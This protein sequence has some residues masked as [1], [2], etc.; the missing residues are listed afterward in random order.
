MPQWTREQLRAIEA[1]GGNVLLSAAAGSGKTTVLVERVLRMIADEGAD[2]DRMLV[3]TF[4]RAAASDMRA[5]LSR[6]LSARAAAGDARCRDQLLLLDRASISTLHAFCADFLRTNFESAGVD[7]AFRILDDAVN[8]RLLDEALTAALEEAYAAGGE[9]LLALDYGR[10]PAGVRAAV[11]LLL[12]RIEDRPDPERW[13]ADAVRGDEA[14]LSMWQ[15]ELV[16][17][18]R[19]CISTALV[20]LRQALA[21]QGCPTNYDGA[22]RIITAKRNAPSRFTVYVAES[23]AKI[24]APTFLSGI[25][26]LIAL[27]ICAVMVYRLLTALMKWQDE[28]NARMREAADT[29]IA[30]GQA[31]SRFLA[32]MSHE[33]R[34][35]INAVLGMN[36]MILRESRDSNILE[37]AS[38]IQTAGKTLLSLIN[39]ILDFSKIEEGKMEIIP[40]QYDT[41]SVINNLVAS[42]SERAKAKDLELIVEV[43]PELPAKMIGD[44]VRLSQVIMNLLTNAVKYTEKGSV[45]FSM[46]GGERKDGNISLNVKVQDTGIGI[47]KEDLPKLFESFERLDEVRNHSIEGTGL[48]MS[49]V[50]S[51]LDMMGS[52]LE[53]ESEYGRGSA[54]SFTV[55]QQIADETPIGDYARRLDQSRR[56]VAKETLRAEKA[57]ILVVDDND[58]NLK[59]AKNLLKLF[60]IVPDLAGSGFECIELMRK[61]HYNVVFLDHMMPKMDGVETLR[62]LKKQA[63]IPEDTKVIVLTANAVLGAKEQYLKDGFDDYLS[64]P[65]D[66]GKLEELLIRI[67]PKE[68]CTLRTKGE[69]AAA[70]EKAE[71]PAGSGSSAVDDLQKAGFDTAAALRFA[72]GD[73]DFYLELASGFAEGAAKNLPAI[74]ADFEKQDWADYQ[75]RVHALKS[76]AKQIGANELSELALRQETAAKERSIPEIE[77]G[78]ENLLS[79]YEQTVQLLRD[80]LHLDAAPAPAEETVELSTEEMR[81]KLNDAKTCISNFEAESALEILKPLAAHSFPDAAVGDALQKI[82]DALEGFDTFTAEE[83]LN[84]LIGR[85]G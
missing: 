39:S 22:L 69:D 14:A 2:V 33:I 16:D 81:A 15:G 49:I 36:E 45:R 77:A 65:I 26:V 63:L 8:A 72:A 10:G 56:S 53:V 50:T 18:A 12:A 64:K 82:I 37:Y 4:T 80:T 75:I 67:L 44:D 55:I 52:R 58:M 11:E 17:A 7:P 21:T 19:R 31:K 41:T 43:D 74:R 28:M 24:Y 47:K 68:L 5:K 32:Q 1:R 35:P 27:L 38:N 23:F 59:V 54:F 20:H 57:R 60:G 62:E 46:K 70:E 66:V 48:G 85:I 6:Q 76:T 3:V 83:A 30:A 42:I 71:E 73:P 29:A 34:T 79:K 40:V 61:E 9:A 13:L 25:L 84:E 51:L 78:A